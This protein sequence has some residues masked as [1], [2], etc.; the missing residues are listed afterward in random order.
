MISIIILAA[1]ESTR[2]G[3]LKQLYKINNK[4]ST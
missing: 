3:E 4:S 2:F 1:G